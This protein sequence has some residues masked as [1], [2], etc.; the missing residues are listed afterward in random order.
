MFRAFEMYSRMP[1]GG[2]ITMTNVMQVCVAPAGAGLLGAGLLGAG[3]LGAG[4][5]GAGL[6]G[7]GLLGAC[8]R[9]A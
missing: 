9:P 2:Y 6:L 1:T 7:A 5:L 8:C 4:L 3:L